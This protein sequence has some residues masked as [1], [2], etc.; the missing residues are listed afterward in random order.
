[1]ELKKSTA[2]S[3]ATALKYERTKGGDVRE[4]VKRR[5]GYELGSLPHPHTQMP[6]LAHIIA[7]DILRLEEEVGSD[8]VHDHE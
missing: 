4:L 3:V 5:L 6:L 2:G 7:C 1:M 8:C